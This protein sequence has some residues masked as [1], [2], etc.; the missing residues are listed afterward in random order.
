M[1]SAQVVTRGSQG[2]LKPCYA[3]RPPSTPL[4][5]T[6]FSLISY[7]CNTMNYEVLGGVWIDLVGILVLFGTLLLFCLY[8]LWCHLFVKSWQAAANGTV[9][10]GIFRLAAARG[11]LQTMACLLSSAAV[12]VDAAAH[13]GF[14]ALHA[15]AVMGQTGKSFQQLYMCNF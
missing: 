7:S 13:D 1:E 5:C 6:L 11:D 3:Q 8:V 15:A 9:K 14:T 10:A 12:D 2:G 4:D